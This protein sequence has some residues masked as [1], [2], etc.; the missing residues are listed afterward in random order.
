MPIA[1]QSI[2]EIVSRQSTAAA[3]LQRFEIDLCSYGDESLQQACA[4]LQLS[5]DQVLERLSEAA[6]NEYGAVPVD[7][8]SYSL[9]RLIQHI[10]RSHHG[11]VRRELPRL[12]EMA[13]K[14]TGKHGERVP[15]LKKT[16]LLLQA[17]HAEMIAHLE[18]EEQVLFPVIAQIE[19]EMAGCRLSAQACFRT[20]SRPIS[21]M[22]REHE[23]A[24]GLVAEISRLT[25]DFQAP[26]WACPTHL[27]LYSGLKS[28]QDDLRQHVHLENDHLFP[29]AIDAESGFNQRG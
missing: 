13:T 19:E 9:T 26:R 7:L 1:T 28:F 24:E 4:D 21:T 29:R 12:I 22:I 5:V 14:L 2:R 17:L 20:I 8:A 6:A 23:S 18:K 10:V 3:V 15:E 25:N 27:A 11:Y 16:E